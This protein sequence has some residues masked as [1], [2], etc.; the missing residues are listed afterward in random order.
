MKWINGMEKV[1]ASIM[2][3]FDDRPK[4]MILYY[5]LILIWMT[6]AQLKA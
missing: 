1:P 2:G 4:T 5:K 6:D 3:P